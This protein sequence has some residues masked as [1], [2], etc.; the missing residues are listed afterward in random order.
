MKKKSIFAPK[1]VCY[2]LSF[3]SPK[4]NN[5][6]NCIFMKQ[7]LRFLMLTLLCAVVSMAWGETETIDFSTLGYSNGQTIEAVNGTDFSVSFNKGTSSNSPA[8]YTSG[9]AIRV[10]GGGYF[11]VSS[12]KT[13]SKIEIT[14]GSSDGSNT[15]TTDCGTYENGT[16]TGGSTSVKFSV[17]GSSGNRR[18]KAIAVTFE[19]Q[20]QLTGEKFE[21]LNGTPAS[22][23]EGDYIITCNSSSDKYAMSN[24]DSN[25]LKGKTDFAM[26]G[27]ANIVTD[28]KTIIWHI[29]PQG[30]YW[31]IQSL[32]DN[33]YAAY[34]GSSDEATMTST[35]DDNALWS[36]NGNNGFTNKVTGTDLRF[37]NNNFSFNSMGTAVFTLYRMPDK[38]YVAGSWTNWATG[39]IEMT[40]NADDTYTLENQEL[41][42]EAQ[43]KIIKVVSA[44]GDPIWCGG[45]AD[46]EYY[47]VT[48]D[49]HTDISLNVGGGEN[50]RMSV[51]GTWTFIVNPTDATLTV[52]GDWPEWEY[53]L[54]GDFNEWATTSI[55]SYKFSDAGLGKFTLNKPIKYGEKFKIYGKRGNEEKWFGAVS[56]GDFWVNAEQVGTELSLTTENGGENFYMNLSNKNS[57]WELEFD[58][59]NM[60]LVLGNFV[61]DIAVL[62]FEFDGGRNAIENTEGLTSTGLGT[63]YGSSPKLKFSSA[64]NAVILHFDERPGTLSFDIKGNGFSGEFVVQTSEDGETYTDLKTYTSLSNA[65]TGQHEIID[66]LGENVRYIKWLYKVKTNGNVALGNIKL[67]KYVAPQS[68]TLNIDAVENGEVFVFYNAPDNYYPAIEDGDEVLEGSEVLVSVSAEEGY[69]IK[70]IAVTDADGQRLQLT[71]E[72]DGISWTFTMPKSDVTVSCTVEEINYDQ[73]EWVL[74]PL[75]DLTE[76]D[77]FV[78]VGNDGDTYAMPND[79]GTTPPDAVTV[80]VSMNKIITPVAD[81]IKWNISGNADDGYIFRPNG[82]EENWL[83]LKDTNKGVCVGES[84]ET[85][86]TRQ[87][88]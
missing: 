88:R 3:Y 50:F 31:T 58:P 24:D 11:T 32:D 5:H 25:N 48:P 83:Y 27:N 56:T 62:P 30:N 10:Y 59:V 80:I 46:G 37:F 61:S 72:E 81:R 68:Y 73:E 82:D 26:D 7:N 18:I 52:D 69:E 14:F 23:V 35:V 47:G 40:K 4:N 87:S 60:T 19:D 15:I 22:I 16:W 12:S 76:D 45:N 20:P 9:T 51:A 6:Q 17:G 39:K 75:A 28:D 84:E 8:Y 33:Q 42:A 67:E 44:A 85:G 63:D 29:A 1:L 49:V 79:K 13:I 55:D 64:N 65:E 38:Y 66:N 77:I 2:A 71:A 70:D 86:R 53:Y 34:A 57:Y 43:F 41:A 21:I 78:I 74:T 54:L 36:Y